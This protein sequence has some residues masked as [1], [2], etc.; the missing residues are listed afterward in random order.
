LEM[1]VL[2]AAAVAIPWQASA[3]PPATYPGVATAQ[4]APPLR[5]SS[6]CVRGGAAVGMGVTIL[7]LP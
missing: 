5:T 1:T 6:L 3:P 4:E 7:A 2:D